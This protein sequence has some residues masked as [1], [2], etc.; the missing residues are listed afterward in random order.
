MLNQWVFTPS[1]PICA[2]DLSQLC[3]RGKTEKMPLWYT[4]ADP[5]TPL[6]DEEPIN[7]AVVLP[8]FCFETQQQFFVLLFA[9]DNMPVSPV[10]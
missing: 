2:F 1:T 8:V 4:S 10:A 7:T 9:R 5:D 6:H 3:Q